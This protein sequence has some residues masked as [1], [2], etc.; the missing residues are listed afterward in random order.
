MKKL[1]LTTGA[2]LLAAGALVT[3]QPSQAQSAGVSAGFLTCQV[4]GGWGLIFSSSRA[5]NCNY[6]QAGYTE[7][8]VGRAD[9]FGIDIG[10]LSGAT[11]AWAVIA[12]TAKLAP[13]TLSGSFAG[14]TGSATVGLGAGADVLFGGSAQTLMLQ[15]VS[16]QGDAGL[17]VAAGIE[18]LNLQ[19]DYRT[20]SLSR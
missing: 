8:Y 7:Q 2:A 14:A 3:A 17:N 13:G 4:D 15:P 20:S 18:A 10:Y 19:P 11:I 9:K 5:L 6:S 12:P 1:A 16:I